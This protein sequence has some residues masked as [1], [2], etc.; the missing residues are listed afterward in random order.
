M[1]AC[2]RHAS[3]EGSKTSDIYICIDLLFVLSA[4][5][6]DESVLKIIIIKKNAKK[7]SV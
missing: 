4:C 6:A 1:S 3:E 5:L 7:K 2:E